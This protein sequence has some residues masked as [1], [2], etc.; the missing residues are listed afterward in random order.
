MT[1]QDGSA[2]RAADAVSDGRL[3]P[4]PWVVSFL[5]SAALRRS[6]AV[7]TSAALAAA[8]V[9]SVY[10]DGGAY[11]LNAIGLFSLAVTAFGLYLAIAIFRRQAAETVRETRHHTDLITELGR[12][13]TRA[14]ESAGKA[15]VN[16]ERLVEYFDLV[17]RE[18]TGRG[19]TGERRDR[20]LAVASGLRRLTG[21]AQILWVDDHSEWIRY[22][23]AAFEE[24]GVLTVWVSNTAQAIA[25]LEGNSFAAV[26]TDMGRAE[27]DSEGFV[28]L[29]AIRGA[30][31]TTPVFVYSGSG[32]PE[33]IQAVLDRG[34]QGATNDPSVL[35]QLV[36]RELMR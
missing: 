12:I 6:V 35:F 27:G 1:A 26:V 17:E 13:S 34:G 32:R 2:D 30:S 11:G 9:T 16:T 36:M 3:G 33:H 28:L 23:R 15:H 5:E 22:E 7:V 31:I 20:A 18:R 8:V 14:A 29:E 4:P 10:L 21:P 25:L 19:L 24:V